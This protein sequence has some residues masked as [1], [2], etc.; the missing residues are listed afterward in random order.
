MSTEF[1][2]ALRAE[3]GEYLSTAQEDLEA[4]RRD[5]SGQVSPARPLGVVNATT[6]EHVQITL[7]L[8]REHNIPVVPRG[9][10]TGLTGAAMASSGE[11]VLSTASM[12]RILEINEADQLAVVEPG[13]L[14]GDLNRTLEPY[15]LWWA[16]DPASK[17]IS[18]IGGNIANNAGGL[19]CAKYGVTREAVLGLKVV[20]TDGTLLEVGHRTVKGVTGYDLTALFIGSEGTLG[21]IV[22]A[23]LKLIPVVP[24]TPT[25]ISAYFSSVREAA[26]ACAAITAARLRPSVMELMDALCVSYVHDYLGLDQKSP[27]SAFVLVQT[28]GEQ[29][30]AEAHRMLEIIEACGGDATLTTDAAEGEELLRIRRAINPAIEAQGTALIEDI[31]VPRSQVPAMFDAIDRISTTYGMPIPTLVHAGDG[32]LHPNFIFD[33]PDV[34]ARVWEAASELFRAG[35]A[36]GGTL[37]GEHGIGLLKK[38]WLRDELGETQVTLQRQIKAVFDPTGILNPGK[39][40]DD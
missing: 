13:V 2:S 26:A 36:L 10:G 31:A 16:P 35:V 37:T 7:R 24:G 25:T 40:F 5:R 8:A 14:N 30:G 18:S 23:T 17:D 9:A 21:V 19:L 1:L 27:G 29:S 4:L 33:G 20:L 38:R 15:G 3:L 34:P 28:D 32:N 22:E 12:T 39:V 6:P 11:L